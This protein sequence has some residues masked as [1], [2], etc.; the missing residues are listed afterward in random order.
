MGSYEPSLEEIQEEESK[1]DESYDS[2][3]EEVQEDESYDPNLE[4]MNEDASY[5][6]GMEYGPE[7]EMMEMNSDSYEEDKLHAFEVSLREQL[8]EIKQLMDSATVFQLPSS[9]EV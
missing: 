4:M 5:E 7:D 2:N 1:E 9:D 3:L 8:K 6:L